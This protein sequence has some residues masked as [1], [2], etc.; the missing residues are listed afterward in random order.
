MI[1]LEDMIAKARWTRSDSSDGCCH[2]E[3]MLEGKDKRERDREP[4]YIYLHLAQIQTT[5]SRDE[6]PPLA[7]TLGPD[8]YR[9]KGRSSPRSIRRA[10]PETRVTITCPVS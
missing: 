7:Y 10:E 2:I 9:G 4:S 5:G 3:V 8:N 1:D 6:D